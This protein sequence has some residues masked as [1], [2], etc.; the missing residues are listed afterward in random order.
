MCGDVFDVLVDVLRIAVCVVVGAGGAEV[1]RFGALLREEQV[2]VL[3]NVRYEVVRVGF[4]VWDVVV[5]VE[6]DARERFALV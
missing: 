6:C 1:V 2:Q 5:V 3:V 4:A